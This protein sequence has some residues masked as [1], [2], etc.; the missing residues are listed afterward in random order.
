MEKVLISIANISTDI[1]GEKMNQVLKYVG[2]VAT[3]IK[4]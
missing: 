3:S 2:D 4:L 1:E